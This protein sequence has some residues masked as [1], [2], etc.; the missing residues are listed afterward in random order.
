M[1]LIPA[2]QVPRGEALTS[3]LH[4]RARDHFKKPAEILNL[5]FW[6]G[7][8][9]LHPRPWVLCLGELHPCSHALWDKETLLFLLSI[10][11]HICLC[12]L[13]PEEA[14][15]APSG[16]AI[17]LWEGPVLLCLPPTQRDAW[18]MASV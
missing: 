15:A 18:H 17:R 1:T 9:S 2:S 11:K 12:W 13:C 5:L 10:P 6:L 4:I 3:S 8:R 14:S 7:L 16:V